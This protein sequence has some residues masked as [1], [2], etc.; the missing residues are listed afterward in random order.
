[1]K[2][3]ICHPPFFVRGAGKTNQR[4]L[5]ESPAISHF[6]PSRMDCPVQCPAR[7]SHGEPR[8]HRFR[9]VVHLFCTYRTRIPERASVS[10]LHHAVA[11]LVLQLHLRVRKK[12]RK[13]VR[14][15]RK[16]SIC[17][18][19][20]PSLPEDSSLFSIVRAFDAQFVTLFSRLAIFALS[21][22][23]HQSS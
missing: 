5:Q 13:F 12:N 10:W 22:L 1:L 23:F 16:K 14:H 8:R 19:D 20:Y 17:W 7:T 15:V 4:A 9:R 2:L 18:K 11:L 6:G 3:Y 21:P